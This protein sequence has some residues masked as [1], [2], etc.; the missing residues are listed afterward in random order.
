MSVE[1][2]FWQDPYLTELEARISGVSGNLVTLDRT[3]IFAF[4]G[5]QQSDEGSIGGHRV[6]AAEKRGREI[7]YSLEEGHGLKS[8]EAVRLCI[9]WPLRYR[10]MK[11]HFAAELVLELVYRNYNHPER[12]GANITADKARVD[13]YWEGSMAS[14]IPDIQQKTDSLIAAD[15]AVISAFSDEKAERRY[16]EIAGFAKVP[17]GGTHLRRSGEIG[18][19][20]LRRSNPG[21]GKERIEI[22]LESDQA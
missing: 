2:I 14:I 18:V 6:L 1:K 9:D 8:G 7:Y 16:W 17:C 19:V 21:K 11:L 4:S 12:I 20:K 22:F 15:H 5:G 10:L 13:F 3:I